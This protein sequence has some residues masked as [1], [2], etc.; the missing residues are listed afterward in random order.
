METCDPCLEGF[1]KV[2][3]RTGRSGCSC[4]KCG[5]TRNG[6]R[7]TQPFRLASSFQKLQ[8]R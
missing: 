1:H 3:C 2:Q 6:R 8:A 7:K 4:S 5:E